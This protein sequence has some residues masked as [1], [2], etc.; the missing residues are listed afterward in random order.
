MSIYGIQSLH[1]AQSLA[2]PHR[3]G[4]TAAPAAETNRQG[5]SIQDEVQISQAAREASTAVVENSE[6]SAGSGI[7][8]DLINH[9]RAEIADGTY[10]TPEKMSIAVDRLA[11]RLNPK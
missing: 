1:S 3:A 2:G 6:S 11:S 7:R 4:A 10:D 5:M 9:I 8:F